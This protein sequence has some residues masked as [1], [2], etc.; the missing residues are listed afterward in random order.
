MDQ[1]FGED[2][3]YVGDS[4][5]LRN[6]VF[7]RIQDTASEGAVVGRGGGASM[8]GVKSSVEVG[9]QECNGEGG[10]ECARLGEEVEVVF[11]K[12]LL[13][14]HIACWSE[15]RALKERLGGGRGEQGAR[16]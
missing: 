14:L 16:T 6:R 4:T 1:K 7:S 5:V 10:Q 8:V 13:K 9:G 15:L 3:E 12:V 2:L 11:S